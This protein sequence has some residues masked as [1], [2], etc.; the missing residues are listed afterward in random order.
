MTPINK[1]SLVSFNK[2]E[3]PSKFLSCSKEI[4]TKHYLPEIASGIIL[5]SSF[6][7]ARNFTLIPACAL[8]AIALT[9]GLSSFNRKDKVENIHALIK[10][11]IGI[12]SI[13]FSFYLLAGLDLELEAQEKILLINRTLTIPERIY[14]F[15][16]GIDDFLTDPLTSFG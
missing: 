16:T 5:A 11:C 4:L 15:L 1:T 12:S 2:F 6:A 10:T 13:F 7:F 3:I 8:G 14:E 9:Q